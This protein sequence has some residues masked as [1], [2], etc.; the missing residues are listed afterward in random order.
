VKQTAGEKR[1]VEG[2]PSRSLAEKAKRAVKA[3]DDR[4]AWVEPGP[5]R[6]VKTRVDGVIDCRTFIRNV[7]ILAEY[8][9]ASRKE[10]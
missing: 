5:M 8:L 3:L 7:G 2:P 9:A 6:Y 10:D 4:G 1:S